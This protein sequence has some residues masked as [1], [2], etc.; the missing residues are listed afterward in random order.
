MFD[1]LPTFYPDWY[2][3]PQRPRTTSLT[4]YTPLTYFEGVPAVRYANQPN[5]FVAPASLGA[6][7]AVQGYINVNFDPL[8]WQQQPNRTVHYSAL[9]GE[10]IFLECQFGTPTLVPKRAA[11]A[12]QPVLE[13]D[14][15]YYQC[16]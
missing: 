8:A 2:F 13:I 10:P 11:T 15:Q 6:V 1:P 9:T 5:L 7:A 14:G 16:R 3:P 12:E 4:Y